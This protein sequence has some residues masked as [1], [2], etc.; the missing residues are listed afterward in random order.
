MRKLLDDLSINGHRNFCTLRHTFR[1]VADEAKDQVA[2]D[3]VMG[4]ARDDMASVYRE[5]IADERV[6][7]VVAHVRVWL[8]A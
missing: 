8:W 3:F 2:I 4:H 5:R 7:S 1:T 6:E